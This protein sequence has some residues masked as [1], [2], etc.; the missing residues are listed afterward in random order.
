MIRTERI[1][2]LMIKIEPLVDSFLQKL[3]PHLADQKFMIVGGLAIR[4]YLDQF[5]IS[6]PIRDFNDID[7][8]IESSDVLLPSVTKDFLVYH[9]HL[10]ANGSFYI[11]LV[12]PETKI[13]IDIFDMTIKNEHSI[14]VP[15]HEYKL[16]I[17]RLEDQFV[18]TIYD[19]ERISEDKKV[20]PK[21]FVEAELLEQIV[22]MKLADK[23]WKERRYINYPSSISL[24]FQRA[25]KI[26]LDHPEWVQEK[27]FRH[28]KAYKC[29]ECLKVDDFP[30]TPMTKIY[31]ILGYTE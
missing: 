8:K 11:V 24:A 7:I 4:Y 1:G 28:T 2:L 31:E 3:L 30:I 6:Y 9:Y 13:K 18:K 21:Q 20:D 17:V 23:I 10:S 22:D 16:K 15:F 25:R 14:K 29:N 5:G 26:A 27:P 12:D 19:I